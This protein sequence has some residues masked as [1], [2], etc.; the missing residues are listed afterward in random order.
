MEPRSFCILHEVNDENCC[1]LITFFWFSEFSVLSFLEA[2][3]NYVIDIIY[4][5]LSQ[6]SRGWVMS[7]NAQGKFI[8]KG[9]QHTP[10]EIQRIDFI[11][12]VLGITTF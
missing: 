3:R 1:Q 8:D 7:T 5:G 12:A 9:D 6:E 10:W 4:K 11:R 2:L